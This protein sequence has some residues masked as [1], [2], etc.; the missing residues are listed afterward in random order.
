MKQI[1]SDAVDHID[2]FVEAAMI[3]DKNWVLAEKIT[4]KWLLIRQF[5]QP[6]KGL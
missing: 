3:L 5:L 1:T 6:L 4:L 2:D